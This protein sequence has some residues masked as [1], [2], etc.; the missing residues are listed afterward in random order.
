MFRPGRPG[1]ADD[2]EVVGEVVDVH[3]DIAQPV[4]PA[5]DLVFRRVDDAGLEGG[6]GDVANVGGRVAVEAAFT[7]GLAGL[8]AMA[9]QSSSAAQLDRPYRALVCLFM[10]GGNDAHNWLVP[11]D[12]AEHAAYT[13]ARGD[14]ACLRALDVETVF[15]AALKR[16]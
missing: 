4:A 2:T 10:N 9:A 8:G 16:L 12:S 14:L 11:L 7:L 3:D 5:H 15:Q 1:G 13:R 6:A